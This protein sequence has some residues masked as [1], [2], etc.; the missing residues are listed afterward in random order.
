[1]KQERVQTAMAAKAA[2]VATQLR[3]AIKNGKP[4]EQAAAAAGVQA[5][6]L[7]AFALLPNP[8]GAPAAKSEPQ[9]EPPDMGAI[10][11]AVSQ[12]SPGS[13]SD[14]TPTPEGGVLVV[15]EKREPL[16]LAQ[17]KSSRPFIEDT[18][19]SN[20]RQILFYEWLRD[21]RRNAGVEE[22]RAPAVANS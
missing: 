10:K 22:N 16:D 18:T 21:R 9:H 19:L 2:S 3:E 17:Y 14:F 13:V 4:V 8:P 5:Q 12:M 20:E 7:P 15:L 1:M 11:Q 6:P